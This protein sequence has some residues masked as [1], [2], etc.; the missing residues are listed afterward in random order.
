MQRRLVFLASLAYAILMYRGD[1]H[2]ISDEPGLIPREED[3]RGE[4]TDPLL[5]QQ[6]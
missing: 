6:R 1:S 5:A 3:G 4:E 2:G